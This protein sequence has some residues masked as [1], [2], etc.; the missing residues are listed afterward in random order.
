VKLEDGGK[1]KADVVGGIT[2]SYGGWGY[3][4][5]VEEADLSSE[6]NKKEKGLSRR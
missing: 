5:M 6:Q 4:L 3:N 1:G 2:E